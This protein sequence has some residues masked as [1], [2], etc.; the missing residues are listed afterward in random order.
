MVLVSASQYP[1]YFDCSIMNPGRL[2]LPLIL[3]VLMLW[4]AAS[5]CEAQTTSPSPAPSPTPSISESQEKVKVFT[6]EV[7]IPVTAYDDS[8]H[9]SASLEPQDILVFEDDV[10]QTVRS[11]R[12]I[13]AN[14]LL[15]LDTGG[16]LNPAMR[17]STTRDIA[18]RLI[19]N[20]R[21]GDRIAAIQFGNHLELVKDWSTDRDQLI[22][23]LN[24]KLISGKRPQ[25][26]KALFT[27]AMQLKQVPAGTRHLVLIAEPRRF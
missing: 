19:F 13:P 5:R 11:V 16:E 4:L 3:L 2:T 20:L 1:N 18:M 9:L 21:T 22:R 17:V 14:V 25:L 27:A 23:T 6:E 10:R 7:I 24:T 12:R 15:L 26:M 8:G